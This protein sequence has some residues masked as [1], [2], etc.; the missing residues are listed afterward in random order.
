MEKDIIGVSE[1]RLFSVALARCLAKVPLFFEE[2]AGGVIEPYLLSFDKGE[3]SI[4]F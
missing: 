4:Y 3:G 1:N 2:G